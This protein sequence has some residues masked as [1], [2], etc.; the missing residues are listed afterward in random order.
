MVNFITFAYY[1]AACFGTMAAVV[2]FTCGHDNFGMLW[3][4][5]YAVSGLLNLTIAPLVYLSTR[6]AGSYM[7]TNQAM[8]VVCTV[9][10]GYPLWLWY[11]D[12]MAAKAVS[13]R[14]RREAPLHEK[15]ALLGV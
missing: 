9:L 14:D 4:V 15:E 12:H 1:R 2:V 7:L 13:A 10:L 3:G 5:L 6:G 8:G 11:Q